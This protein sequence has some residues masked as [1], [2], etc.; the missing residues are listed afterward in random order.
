MKQ[1]IILGTLA[2]ALSNCKNNGKGDKPET[3][4]T[5]KADSLVTATTDATKPASPVTDSEFPSDFKPSQIFKADKADLH[6]SLK[7]QQLSE[8]KIAYEVMMESGECP[9]FSYR[10]IAILK[11]G[12]VESDSDENNNSFVVDEF[13]DD[14]NGNCGISI[15][16]GADQGYKDR[17]RFYVYDCASSCKTKQESEPLRLSRN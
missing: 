1:L 9:Q 2:L 14:S 7:V 8:K 15:R 11:D 12:D 16:I 6:E 10:G 17:A 3:D 5:N 4:T 13:V